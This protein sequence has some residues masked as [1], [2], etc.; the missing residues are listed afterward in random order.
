[1]DVGPARAAAHAAPSAPRY[2]MDVDTARAAAHAFLD[3]VEQRPIGIGYFLYA[4]TIS[5]ALPKEEDERLK[6]E[7]R[8]KIDRLR[9]RK[10]E[11]ELEEGEEERA[12]SDAGAALALVPAPPPAAAA[13]PLGRPSQR[14]AA[15]TAVAAISRLAAS[16]A[17]TNNMGTELGAVALEPGSGAYDGSCLARRF[18]V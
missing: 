11:R 7:L 2:I 9:K 8:E 12:G 17:L 5:E 13:Q 3:S 16:E 15:M 10:R 4:K 14:K 1:M 18:C 6:H